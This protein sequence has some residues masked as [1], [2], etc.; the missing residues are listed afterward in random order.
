MVPIL[1]IGH[2]TLA[3]QSFWN[4]TQLSQGPVPTH[5]A[6]GRARF[7]A[8]R[9]EALE[10][11]FQ[12]KARALRE[13]TG[14]PVS[15][16][17]RK[18]PFGGAETGLQRPE[19]KDTDRIGL[20][21]RYDA[22]TNV[23]CLPSGASCPTDERFNLGQGSRAGGQVLGD[24]RR[25]ERRR[26]CGRVAQAQF[27]KSNPSRDQFRQVVPPLSLS[28]RLEQGDAVPT[29]AGLPWLDH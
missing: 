20:V 14:A 18:T 4:R 28:G 23:T 2:E 21:A 24:F 1:A 15:R 25:R 7:E 10:P 3:K 22:E 17:E 27:P 5:V 11:K 19:L 26:Q 13:Q 6:D 12:Q 16:V 9:A 8:H 29:R